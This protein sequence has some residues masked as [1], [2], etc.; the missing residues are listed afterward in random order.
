[1]SKQNN[2]T[3]LSIAIAIGILLGVF[4]FYSRGQLITITQMMFLCILESFV[5]I[6]ILRA[7]RTQNIKSSTL[8]SIGV[9][10]AFIFSHCYGF[11]KGIET[12]GATIEHAAIL[13]LLSNCVIYVVV[14][15]IIAIL[16]LKI[17]GIMANSRQQ[18]W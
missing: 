6:C 7:I 15:M 4:C 10:F 1:M 3:K 13:R 14:G 18:H 12:G 5:C 17:N 9:A 2:L 11:I 8:S 16:C